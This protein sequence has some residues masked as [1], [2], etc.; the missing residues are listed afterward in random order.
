MTDIE[1]YVINQISV[2]LAVSFPDAEVAGDYELT[3]PNG[4][5]PRVCV[6]QSD[7]ETYERSL[8]GSV[9]PNHETVY[10]T[11][12]VF[13]NALDGRKAEAKAI[14]DAVDD[15]MTDMLFIRTM[16]SPT[17]NI[18]RSIYRLTARYRAVHADAKQIGDDDVVQMYRR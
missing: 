9:K 18:D 17:P 7:R 11:V 10:F 14:M 8:D 4:P 15:I 12:D 2:G 6:S 5:F 3:D 1:N 13:S 16:C